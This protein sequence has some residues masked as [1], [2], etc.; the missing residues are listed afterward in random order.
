MNTE[1]KKPA[2]CS[3]EIAQKRD[4]LA[5]KLSELDLMRKRTIRRALLVV[6][7][8][9]SIVTIA[10]VLLGFLP[11]LAFVFTTLSTVAAAMSAA[12][13]FI[14]SRTKTPR[15]VH[16]A[17]YSG[18]LAFALSVTFDVSGVLA[19]ICVVVF[20]SATVFS[21]IYPLHT[22][23]ANTIALQKLFNNYSDA[24]FV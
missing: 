4:R 21:V 17:T 8:I 22:I 19:L 2:L 1:I 20:V 9:F 5:A 23:K 11:W 15:P 7:G 3:G 12:Y 24:E 18:A 16:V 6:L 10:N 14:E 13:A